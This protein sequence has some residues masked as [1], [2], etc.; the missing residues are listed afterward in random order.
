[1]AEQL[2]QGVAPE[3]AI[4]AVRVGLL[5]ALRKPDGGVCW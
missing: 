5:T 4:H 1:M 2:A 3:A